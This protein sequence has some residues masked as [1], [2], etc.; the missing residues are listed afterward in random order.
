MKIAVDID[1]VIGDQVPHVLRRVNDRL[2]R[3][4]RKRDIRSWN[5]YLNGTDIETEIERALLDDE[6]IMGMPIYRGARSTLEALKKRGYYIIIATSRPPEKDEVTRKW[7]RDR[8]IPHDIFVNTR[9]TGKGMITADVLIDDN[10]QNIIEFAR[11]GRIGILFL[12]PW[13]SSNKIVSRRAYVARGWSMV[14]ELL[15]N[16]RTAKLGTAK[17]G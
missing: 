3:R 6:F 9:R 17:S 2:G 4:Y 16:L 8:K 10:P 14:Y 15:L 7:L 13:N 11:K 1:G 5:Q 12:Q